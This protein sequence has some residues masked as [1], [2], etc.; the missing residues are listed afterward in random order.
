MVN[1]RRNPCP[2]NSIDFYYLESQPEDLFARLFV[3]KV[4]LVVDN[5]VY[6]YGY[7]LKKFKYII[8]PAI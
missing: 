2:K 1:V 7:L 3:T 5:A 8:T 4:A 6:W